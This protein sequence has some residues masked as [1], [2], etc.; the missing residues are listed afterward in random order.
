MQRVLITGATGFIGGHL[1][2][3]LA[4]QGIETRCLVRPTSDVERLSALGAT[5]VE[6][7]VTKA[8]GLDEAV[9]GVDVVFHLAGLIT[10]LSQAEMMQANASGTELVAAAC[11]RRETPPA[12]ILLSSV[13]AA[14]PAARDAI[15]VENDPLAPVSNYGHSKRAGEL[16]AARWADRVPITTVRPGIVFGPRDRLTLPIFKTIATWRIHPVVGLGRT[17]LALLH[18]DDLVELILKAASDGERLPAPDDRAQQPG[19]GVYFAAHDSAPSYYDFGLLIARA[20]NRRIAP[21]F[22]LP[23]AAWSAAAVSQLWSQVRRRPDAFNIDKI[24]E[25]VQPSWAISNAKAKRQLDWQPQ[26]SL[27]EQIRDTVRW[28]ADHQW[29]K[30]RSLRR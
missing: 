6:G 28:Y 13:A 16:A 2:E 5:L 20:M 25:A 24:R 12:M 9:A 14:G 11:A 26:A 3:A 18:V 17:R 29:I 4:R 7:D 15:R 21:F 22:L 19:D 30:V 1:A 23:A 27:D 10:S 8:D